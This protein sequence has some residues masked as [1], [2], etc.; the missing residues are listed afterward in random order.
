M[1]IFVDNVMESKRLQKQEERGVNRDKVER[2]LRR[3]V[4]HCAS[5]LGIAEMCSQPGEPLKK[6]SED[7][8]DA[9][10]A[11]RIRN[12][13]KPNTLNLVAIG[14]QHVFGCFTA[15][16]LSSKKPEDEKGAVSI[17]PD[18]QIMITREF[19]CELIAQPDM[20]LILEHLDIDSTTR[21]ELFDVL[22]ADMSGELDLDELVDGLMSLRGPTEKK[23]CVGTLLCAR[24]TQQM[25]KNLHLEIKDDRSRL[26]SEQQMMK[27]QLHALLVRQNGQGSGI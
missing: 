8:L 17:L 15:R 16:G 14:L 10:E 13:L 1:A 23:D 7:H 26:W 6:Q 21:D 27:R 5:R 20:E 11:R 25:L 19:F 3:V 18:D 2:E 4:S 22:D 9:G 12:S 24:V